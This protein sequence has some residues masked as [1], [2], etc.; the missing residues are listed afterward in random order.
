MFIMGQ[1]E[2]PNSFQKKKNKQ[3]KI[4]QDPNTQGLP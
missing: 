1:R 2:V 3:I 4:Y